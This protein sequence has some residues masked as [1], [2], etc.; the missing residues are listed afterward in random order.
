MRSPRALVTSALGDGS[1]WNRHWP[2][3]LPAVGRRLKWRIGRGP[4]T[5]TVQSV[6]VSPGLFGR[7]RSVRVTVVDVELE[8]VRLE[9]VD[10]VAR[11]VRLQGSSVRTEHVELRLRLDQIALDALTAGMPYAKLRLEGSVGRAE[12]VAHPRWGHVELSPQVDDGALVLHPTAVG[13]R[14]GGRW[15]APARLLPRLRIG[16]RVLMPGSRLTAAEVRDGVLRLEAEMEDVT[17]P[18][19]AEQGRRVRTA[20]G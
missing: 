2:L 6:S 5:F 16:A 15:T 14:S 1:P 10:I 3:L 17:I 8:Q 11:G 18:L 20:S 19:L 13:T 7:V 12:L 4:V 9:R